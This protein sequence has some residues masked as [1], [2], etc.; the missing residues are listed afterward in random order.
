[1]TPEQRV[2][3]EEIVSTGKLTRIFKD[4]EDLER[5]IEVFAAHYAK[6]VNAANR[7]AIPV[8]LYKGVGQSNQIGTGLWD[9]SKHYVPARAKV[10]RRS[11]ASPLS[12]RAI[13]RHFRFSEPRLETGVI[14]VSFSF[15]G[16]CLSETV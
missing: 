16:S 3:L 2:Q 10:P 8:P 4:L 11:S 14:D 9:E 15:K 13:R 1:M 7:G 6:K 12:N 5:R